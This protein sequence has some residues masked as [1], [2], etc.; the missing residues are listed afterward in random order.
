MTTSAA[1]LKFQPRVGRPWSGG[2]Y[3]GVGLIVG[4][5]LDA[6]ATW[7]AATAW[8]ASVCAYGHTDFT[9][10]SVADLRVLAATFPKF[11]GGEI[12]WSCEPHPDLP[13][14]AFVCHVSAGIVAHWAKLH[15]AHAVAVRRVAT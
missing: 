14:D 3:A 2:V 15:P 10:P 5:L 13:T 4:P 12:W 1:V 11:F 7:D 9:L 6:P 8:A